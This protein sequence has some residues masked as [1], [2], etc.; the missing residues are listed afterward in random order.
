MSEPGVER[1]LMRL[2][3]RS[4][5]DLWSDVDGWH[6]EWDGPLHLASRP[7]RTLATAVRSVYDEATTPGEPT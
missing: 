1:M 4:P 7:Q 6:C 2:V 3:G 5:V